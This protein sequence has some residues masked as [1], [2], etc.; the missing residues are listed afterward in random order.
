MHISVLSLRHH[1]HRLAAVK[2]QRSRGKLGM[3]KWGGKKN[4]QTQSSVRR[5]HKNFKGSESA[6]RSLF[7]KRI[8]PAPSSLDCMRAESD[9]HCTCGLWTP[10][11]LHRPTGRSYPGSQPVGMKRK[12][13]RKRGNEKR[14][15][16]K[17]DK[18]YRLWKQALS[19]LAHNPGT[20]L[21][22]SSFQHP[23]A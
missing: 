17:Q 1:Y 19:K 12:E 18:C 6:I 10:D 3:T 9:Y 22:R 20:K 5:V 4:I 21:T 14:L 15:L 23:L 13:G 2:Q 7:K 16:Y 8:S 11:C